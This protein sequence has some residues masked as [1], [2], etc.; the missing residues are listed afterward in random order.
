MAEAVYK[1]VTEAAFETARHERRFA[2]SADDRRDGF[3]HLST[4]DQVAGTLASHFSGQTGLLLLGVDPER[5][6]SD[7]KWEP[8]R[9]GALFP[10]LYGPLDLEAVLSIDRLSLDED[11]R[12]TLPPGFRA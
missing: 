6:G 5:L 7:L 2:G 4:A 11:G 10:H 3:I 1:I 12:H 9:G 8:S